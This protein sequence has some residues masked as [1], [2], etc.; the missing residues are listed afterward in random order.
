MPKPSNKNTTRCRSCQEKIRHNANKC[1]YCG[2]Y[3]DWRRF[4]FPYLNLIGIS[5]AF[6]SLI[7][8][9]WPIIKETNRVKDSELSIS[10]QNFGTYL[11]KDTT[12]FSSH[13]RA[14]A[15]CTL[16]NSTD[17]PAYLTHLKV[18]L[19]SSKSDTAVSLYLYS[20][21]ER[22][23]GKGSKDVSFVLPS[24]TVNRWE[25]DYHGR[26]KTV[27][28]SLI[29]SWFLENVS[30]SRMST[31][32]KVYNEPEVTLEGSELSY[33]TFNGNLKSSPLLFDQG[34]VVQYVNMLG[35]TYFWKK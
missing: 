8:A 17:Y 9:L 20:I 6:G 31:F 12:R 15:F 7:I 10:V 22:L 33:R 19:N 30:I 34:R 25:I 21:N 26:K 35:K 32:V 18:R 2:S 11:D 4:V 23:I 24:M 29:Q 3:Q 28:E 16:I 27:D 1:P 14:S 5:V 13:R